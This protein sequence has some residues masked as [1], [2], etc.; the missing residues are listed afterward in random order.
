MSIFRLTTL[1][2]ILGLFLF[3]N[4]GIS[5]STEK[6]K[7]PIESYL[8]EITSALIQ[9]RIMSR[10]SGQ[11]IDFTFVSNC[12]KEKTETYLQFYCED[13]LWPHHAILMKGGYIYLVEDGDSVENRALFKLSGKKAVTIKDNLPTLL[14][15]KKVTMLLNEKFP[16][17][18]MTEARL[19]A[20][21]HSHY[22]T[23]VPRGIDQTFMIYPGELGEENQSYTE[24]PI[25]K[26]AWT[27]RK[28]KL[29]PF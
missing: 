7:K 26:A 25:G 10:D 11:K 5:K 27:G 6:T 17:L 24:K 13:L 16:K 12:I 1:A 2:A 15:Y 19:K 18:N 22:R 23:K 21:A 14:T 28:F 4:I 9:S 8:Q 20:I 29:L 3:C